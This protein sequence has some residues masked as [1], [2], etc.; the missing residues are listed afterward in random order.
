MNLQ[1][2][3]IEPLEDILKPSDWF[4]GDQECVTD[5]QE[6]VT[7]LKNYFENTS[8][9]LVK[10]SDIQVVK[11]GDKLEVRLTINDSAQ[12]WT[13]DYLNGWIDDKMV[14]F[15]NRF[16]RRNDIDQRFYILKNPNWGQELGIAFC[17][18]KQSKALSKNGW[19][20]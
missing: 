1:K 16:L 3:K 9:Q 10:L 12:E 13:L 11:K 6:Y 4:L 2:E 20:K 15:M 19:L 7:L 5:G 17:T 14:M 8:R 18:K